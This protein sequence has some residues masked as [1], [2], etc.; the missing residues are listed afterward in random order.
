[1]TDPEKIKGILDSCKTACVAMADGGQPYV[2]PMSY[3]Y[4]LRDGALTLFFH[5]AKEG[6]KIDILKRNPKVCFA[7]FNEGEVTVAPAACGSGIFYSSVIGNGLAEFLENPGE[8]REALSAMFERQTGRKVE[9]TEAQASAVCVFKI[10]S[11]D[12]TGKQK[13]K[14]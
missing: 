7:I 8:K 13:S 10:V 12:F 6:K 5:S 4:A 1:M 11:T 14:K 2:A 9:F 3:G